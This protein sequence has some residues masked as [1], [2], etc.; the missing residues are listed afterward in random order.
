MTALVGHLASPSAQRRAEID[1]R[2]KDFQRASR[3]IYGSPQITK[4]FDDARRLANEKTVATHVRAVGLQG[5]VRSTSYRA[6]VPV[7]VKEPRPPLRRALA[8]LARCSLTANK[9]PELLIGE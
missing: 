6:V 8:V 1:A 4:D 2:I 9:E 7:A 5:C 3:A